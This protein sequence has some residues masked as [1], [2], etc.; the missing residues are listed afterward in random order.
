MLEI[1]LLDWIV[2]QC[3]KN[4]FQLYSGKDYLQYIL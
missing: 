2:Q 1:V 3:Q 4:L